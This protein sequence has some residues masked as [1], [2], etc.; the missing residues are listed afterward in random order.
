[1]TIRFN[2]KG[3]ASQDVVRVA[4][5]STEHSRNSQHSP[6]Y[7]EGEGIPSINMSATFDSSSTT[8]GIDTVVIAFEVDPSQCDSDSNLWVTSSTQNL[9]KDRP[10]SESL[11]GFYVL[12]NLDREVKITI[13][14]YVMDGIC[15]I[16]LNAARAV[17]SNK[18]DLLPPDALKPLIEG[19]IGTLLHVVWPRFCTVTSDGEI[20]WKSDW[21]KEV[22]IK[23]LDIAR[24]FLVSD[25]SQLRQVV[26]M[27]NGKY[28]RGKR[29]YDSS[30]GRWT[31]EIPTVEVGK[32]KLYNKSAQ[33]AVNPEDEE[34]MSA[35]SGTLV[36][37]EAQLM[38]SRLAAYGLNRLALVNEESVRDALQA[39]WDATGW[40]SPLPQR[41]DIL[42]S[43]EPL[44]PKD[45]ALL[46][47]YLHLAAVNAH[48]DLSPATQRYLRKLA[49]ECG[50]VAGMPVEL[51]GPSTMYL[52][53]RTGNEQ[54]VSP[55]SVAIA[56]MKGCA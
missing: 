39:R 28:Q 23:R 41:G 46:I 42:K 45:R 12:P 9:R 2:D 47:G 14:L 30:G 5:M 44:K 1:M 48:N 40:G 37:F 10:E 18:E 52:D 56:Q 13:N 53:L 8:W 16:S 51:S 25:A 22:R 35:M 49:M 54:P 3:A 20:L 19:L 24:N 11:R 34:R 15:H 33:L 6:T 4:P 32:D 38:R 27:I 50:L 17:F 29:T 36:R 55:I 31:I 26:P 21:A 43:V 7:R